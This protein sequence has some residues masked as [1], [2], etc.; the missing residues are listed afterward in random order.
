MET[1]ILYIY[2]SIV[3]VI[4]IYTRISIGARMAI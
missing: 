3:V 4:A 1:R 2:I